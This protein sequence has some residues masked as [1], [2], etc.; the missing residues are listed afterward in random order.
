MKLPASAT[1]LAL[2]LLSG[3]GHTPDR[4]LPDRSLSPTTEAGV[5]DVTIKVPTELEA[6]EMQVVY[7][8]KTCTFTDYTASG[9]PYDRDG[10]QQ[11][12]LKPIQRE[13]SR[14]FEAKVPVNGGG[15]CNWQ[16]S[17][18]TFGAEYK[19][20]TAFGEGIKSGFPAGMIVI[21]DDNRSPN[22]S[23][24][25][26]VDGDL[27][28]VRDYYPWLSESFLGGHRRS[29][30]LTTN[31]HF[32]LIYQALHARNVY[33]EPIL[34]SNFLTRSVHPKVKQPGNRTVFHYPDGS[35]SFETYTSP[36]HAKLQAIRMAA[37]AQRQAPADS[38][39]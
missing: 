19:D 21:F 8:S 27:K 6:M 10:Y 5:V 39:G 17:N 29:I 28:V 34:H 1:I 2:L 25:F 16:L 23:W 20:T 9:I 22:G 32:Y 18:I 35:S 12:D 30:S 14:L 13:Q 33:F 31:G 3:C 24:D 37:E 11:M 15:T 7:R 26:K 36:N 38:E 4:E